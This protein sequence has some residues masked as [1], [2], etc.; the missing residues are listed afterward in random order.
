MRK[1]GVE[2]ARTRSAAGMIGRLVVGSVVDRLA[3]TASA[4]TVGA[5]KNAGI[6]R[7]VNPVSGAGVV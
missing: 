5:K 1:V 7:P 4:A 3:A 6:S 2:R